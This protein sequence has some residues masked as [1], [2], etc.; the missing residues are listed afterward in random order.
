MLPPEPDDAPDPDRPPWSVDPV[1]G[2]LPCVVDEAG[3]LGAVL[4]PVA[5]EGLPAPVLVPPLPCLARAVPRSF[6]GFA[7]S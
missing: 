7:L 1:L 6:P 5:V 2:A 4:F 3:A